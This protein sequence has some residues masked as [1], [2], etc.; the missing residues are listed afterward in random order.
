MGN[1][2]PISEKMETEDIESAETG[3][4]ITLIPLDLHFSLFR[5]L[6]FLN[7]GLL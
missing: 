4:M 1:A 7:L 6:F 3:K 2:L 5:R